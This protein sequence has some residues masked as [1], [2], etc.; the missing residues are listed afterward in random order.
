MGL[1][2]WTAAPAP[3][4]TL[5]PNVK[6]PP[7]KIR[8]KKKSWKLTDHTCAC[9]DLTNFEYEAHAN[10]KRKL[11]EFVES[12]LYKL[13]KWLELNLILA[14]FSH[15]KLLWHAATWYPAVASASRAQAARRA[16]RLHWTSE[17]QAIITQLN[18]SSCLHTWFCTDW[19]SQIESLLLSTT[20]RRMLHKYSAGH[21]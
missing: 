7:K 20:C 15:L 4:A 17:Q 12:C 19:V 13:V 2:V 9:N 18:C 10:R 21:V 5:G 1:T 11:W 6:I 3:R 14:G 8:L 16:R